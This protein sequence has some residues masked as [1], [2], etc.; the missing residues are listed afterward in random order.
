MSIMPLRKNTAALATLAIL[1]AIGI[2]IRILVKFTIIPD[3]VEITPAF[4][5]SLLAGILGGVPGGIF[6]GGIVGLAG[7]LA[8]GESPLIPMVGNI[9]LGVG[10]GWVIHVINDRDSMRYRLLVILSG[11]IIGGFISDVLILIFLGVPWDLTLITATAD[12]LM[13]FGWVILA[14]ILESKFIRPLFGHY[15]Y[16]EESIRELEEV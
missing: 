11:G 16:P 14:L 13:A 5:F 2:V 1:A 10:T 6:V 7:A 15:L 8:G 9:L 3:L 12:M 4:L